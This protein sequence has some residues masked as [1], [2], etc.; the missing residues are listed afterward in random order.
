[1][2]DLPTYMDCRPVKKILKQIALSTYSINRDPEHF[3]DENNEPIIDTI[4]AGHALKRCLTIY[5]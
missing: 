1:M 5:S 2:Y 4:Y 3:K